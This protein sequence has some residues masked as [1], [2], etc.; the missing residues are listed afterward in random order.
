MK[1]NCFLFCMLFLLAIPVMASKIDYSHLLQKGVSFT[2]RTLTNADGSVSYDWVG[3]YLQT[4]FTGGSIVLEASEKGTSYHNVYIDDQFV[5]RIKISGKEPQRIVLAE[6]LSNKIHRLRL[7]KITEAYNGC[8]TIHGFYLSKGGKLSPVAP[9]KRFIEVF[10]DSY[11]CGY[12]TEASGPKERFKLETEDFDHSF[13]CLIARYFD[14]DYAVEAHSGMGMV[15]NYGD[16]KQ[17]SE[18]NL[19]TRHTQ[20]FDDY[21]STA[22]DFKA[23]KPDIVLIQLGTNDFS[24]NNTPTPDQYVGNY[25]KMIQSLRSHYGNVPILCILPYSAG[26]YLQTA[27]EVLK[28]RMSSDKDVHIAEPML[29]IISMKNDLG[30]DFHPNT[31]GQQ[32]IAMKLIPQ[33]STITG[34]NLENKV[35]K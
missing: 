33:I 12:G 19:Y 14:A 30:A 32:K 9:K 35:I 16:K 18:K 29:K 31:Q 23:Y 2:G 28:E 4:D 24:R 5:S 26:T 8:T 20:I 3:V 27:F 6:N 25:E 17:T 1:R 10:G 34:W 7:Q 21:D 22:Y 11:T 13:A 15:R